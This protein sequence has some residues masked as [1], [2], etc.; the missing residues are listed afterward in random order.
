MYDPEDD[1]E[2][3]ENERRI[4]NTIRYGTIAEVNYLSARVKVQT[5]EILTDWLPWVTER[6]A[7]VSTWNPPQIGEQVVLLAPSG[8]LAQAVVL[9]GFYKQAFPAPSNSPNKHVT[10]YPDGSIVEYDFDTHILTVTSMGKVNVNAVEEVNV[11]CPT[12]NIIGNVFIQ[13]NFTFTGVGSLTGDLTLEGSLT[14]TGG[15]LSSN[16]IVLDSHRH[17]GVQSGGSQTGMP[18]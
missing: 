1:F 2:S 17:G 18:V 10:Q 11:T 16:G 7:T 15:D 4:A 9:P 14:Q 6:A 3:T 13:G 8:E 5:E 12:V